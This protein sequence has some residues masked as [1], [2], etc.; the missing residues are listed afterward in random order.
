MEC[1]ILLYTGYN[2]Y[3]STK[4]SKATSAGKDL[5]KGEP[6][7]A[8]WP[9]DNRVEAPQGVTSRMEVALLPSRPTKE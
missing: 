5:E 7:L 4:Q 8:S 3:L 9:V 2:G 1:I 6:L